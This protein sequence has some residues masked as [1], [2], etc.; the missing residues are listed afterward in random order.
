MRQGTQDFGITVAMPAY[1]AGAFIRRALESILSQEGV[2][3]EIIVVDD[4]STDDTVE[5]ARSINDSRCRVLQNESRRGIGYCHNRI[6]RE[7]RFEIIS[8][9][10]ADDWI[11]KGALSKLAHA[12]ESDPKI[13]LAHCYYLDVDENG[14]TTIDEFRQRRTAFRRQRPVELDYRNA[15][16]RS[17]SYANALRTYR[18]STL[19]DLGGFNEKIPFGIDYDMALRVLEQH[20]I[21]LVPEFLYVRRLHSHNTTE[22]L[23]WKRYRMWFRKYWIRRSLLRGGQITYWSDARFDLAQFLAQEWQIFRE[24]IRSSR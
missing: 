3:L 6:L 22:S 12:L 19:R 17:A 5:V 4:A 10:D 13:G 7:S 21:R 20:E 16:G 14:S 15:L 11:R 23:R 1:N 18:R 8:H 24:R 2:E 9:V